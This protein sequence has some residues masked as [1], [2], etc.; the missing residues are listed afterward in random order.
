MYKF[1]LLEFKEIN[2]KPDKEYCPIIQLCD[3]YTK[4]EYLLSDIFSENFEESNKNI[5][6]E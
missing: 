5:K 6:T 4:K 2:L 3:Y 1:K